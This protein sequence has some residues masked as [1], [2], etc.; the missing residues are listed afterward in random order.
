MGAPVHFPCPSCGFLVF[1][2]P[3]GSYDICPL[4]GWEDD[5][6]QLIHPLLQGGANRQSLAESQLEA[7][8]KWPL[9]IREHDSV[10][11]DSAWRPLREEELKV[12]FDTPRDGQSYFDATSEEPSYYW[13]SDEKR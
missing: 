5:H 3:S 13:L 6:V 11:R 1:S 2:E 7:L 10:L 4:C 12:S 8:K 9:E